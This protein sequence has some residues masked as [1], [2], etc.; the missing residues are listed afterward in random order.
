M[1]AHSDCRPAR[2]LAPFPSDPLFKPSPP[3]P[4]RTKQSNACI[5]CKERKTKPCDK[6][7]SSGRNCVFVVGRDRRKKCAQRRAEQE[8]Q[9]VLRMLDNIIEAFNA[10]DKTQLD[11]LLFAAREY[12]SGR[13]VQDDIITDTE[14]VSETQIVDS[15]KQTFKEGVDD[16]ARDGLMSLR[17]Q[18]YVSRSATP[19]PTASSSISVEF[20]DEVDTLTEDPNR[21]DASRAI[22]YIGKASEIAWLQK[23]CT[24]VNK[25]NADRDQH[26]LSHIEDSITSMNYHLDHMRIPET[27]SPEPRSLPP[28]QWAAHLLSFFFKSVS[29]SFPLINKSLFNFQFDQAFTYS[30]TQPSRKWLAVFN[31]VLAVGFRCYRLS[32][33]VSGGDTD[34][35]VF[36][37]RAIALSTT[38]GTTSEYMG[39]Y[40]VQIDLLLAIYYL[41][42]GQVNQSWQA[43]GRAARLAISMGLNLRADGN[44]IDPVSKETRVRI[45]WSIFALE[46]VLSSMTGRTPC[47]NYQSMSVYLPLP[48]DEAQ[49]QL[50]EVEELLKN[51]A[52]R[53]RRLRWTIHAS[54]TELNAR[55]QWL[56][57]I[58]SSQSLY[59][60]HLVDLSVIMHAATNVVYRVTATT[61]RFR[62]K[63]PF[64]RG[65]LQ[66]WLSSLQPAFAFT[67][68]NDDDARKN[69]ACDC[70]EQVGLAIAYY[71]SQIIL[72]RPCLTHPDFKNGTNIR[73]PRTRFEEDTAKSCVHFALAL[74]SVLPD[75]PD[76]KWISNMVPWWIL[77]HS[78]MRALTVLLIQLSIS[79]V[80]V[81]TTYGEQKREE[82]EGEG[83]EAVRDASK[84][85]LLWL[86]SMASQDSSSKRAFHI[87]QRLFYLVAPAKA[88][89]SKDAPSAVLLAG[90]E[91]SSGLQRLDSFG[92]GSMKLQEDVVNWGPDYTASESVDE[93]QQVPLSLDP[94][95]LS[96]DSYEF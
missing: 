70:R 86:H 78:I 10:G 92:P 93:Q 40:Q 96:F 63:I 20:L 89:D 24:E 85:A 26:R 68:Y 84:K 37:S 74:L 34:D 58:G 57:T 9:T 3:V 43:N 29:P 39:L 48:Y 65:K 41:S 36:L 25:L 53:E 81:M 76:I 79:L 42:S 75:K 11:C 91:A 21:D 27:V 4:R 62:S 1:T 35:N 44:Q 13:A 22:G 54:N 60:F 14:Q 80:P 8:L 46:H 73:I 83:I 6:C 15:R 30:R 7:I 33:P 23:L 71:S 72:N 69:V 16:L 56:R 77:L 52:S 32:E 64:Y 31:L 50:P 17:L 2:V 88:L 94:V 87:C 45:W 90:E 12:H 18:K 38:P 28:K 59:F 51:A 49:F 55:D 67:T 61:D 95:L 47:V 82:N 5:A 19:I 66:S